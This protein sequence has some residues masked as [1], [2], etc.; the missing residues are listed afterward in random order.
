MPLVSG[1]SKETLEARIDRHANQNGTA[2]LGGK[3]LRDRLQANLQV[4]DD[5]HGGNAGQ[6]LPDNLPPAPEPKL[7]RERGGRIVT[8]SLSGP[9]RRLTSVGLAY[10]SDHALQQ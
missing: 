9:V 7:A 8:A 10:P 6:P 3:G 5:E 1:E 4:M 2:R